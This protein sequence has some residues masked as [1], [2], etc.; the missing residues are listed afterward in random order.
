VTTSKL[1]HVSARSPTAAW[2]KCG[3]KDV[4]KVQVPR[5]GTCCKL[6]HGVSVAAASTGD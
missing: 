5:V 4:A 6:V 3:L 2:W 1:S